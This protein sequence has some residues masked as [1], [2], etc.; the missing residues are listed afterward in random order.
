M[1]A[2]LVVNDDDVE[3]LTVRKMEARYVQKFNSIQWNEEWWYADCSREGI[4][5]DLILL[6]GFCWFVWK[7]VI[8]FRS[9]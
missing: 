4:R 7:F 6:C 9:S 8:R 2:W 3:S 1:A 5:N